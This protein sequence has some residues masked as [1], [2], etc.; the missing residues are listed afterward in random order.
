M[1]KDRTYFEELI[2]KYFSEEATPAEISELSAWVSEDAE[3]EAIFL[4]SRYA[5]IAFE[6]V[7]VAGSTDVDAAWAAFKGRVG[8]S[9][10]SEQA[11]SNRQSAVGSSQSVAGN[12]QP[13]YQRVIPVYTTMLRTAAVIVIL[14]IPSFF[15]YRYL[16]QPAIKEFAAVTGRAETLLPD[17]SHVTLNTGAVIR[18]PEK[19]KGKKRA[20]SLEGEAYFDVAHNASIP[21]IIATDGIRVEVKG[22]SF[23]IN[24]HAWSGDFELVLTSGKVDLFFDQDG[25]IRE[26]EPGVKQCIVH[27]EPGQKAVI[28]GRQIT[29]SPNTDANYMAWKT[30]KITF[31]NETLNDVAATL[32]KVYQ[33]DVCLGNASLAECRLT[34]TFDNQSLESV[35]NVLK[36]TLDVDIRNSGSLVEISGKGCR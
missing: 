35:L 27:V 15:L 30:H 10:E 28:H 7:R 22:T 11:D 25:M 12:R 24:T 5:W 21:F 34:A 20:V 19:F 17:G 33:A 4:E 3:N 8:I 16:K 1:E 13:F 14:A 29:V 18:Y 23:Y 6:E 31:N 9:E 26:P 2:A 32:S 36:A